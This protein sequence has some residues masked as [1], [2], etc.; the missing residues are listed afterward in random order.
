M[1]CIVLKNNYEH[2]TVVLRK[3]VDEDEV[4]EI[5]ENKKTSLF[6]IIFQNYT[7]HKIHHIKPIPI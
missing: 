7:E 5:V 2:K 3:K 4:L 6:K 1:F